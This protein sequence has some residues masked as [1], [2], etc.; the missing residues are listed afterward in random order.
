MFAE[1]SKQVTNDDKFKAPFGNWAKSVQQ[2]LNYE[3]AASR[4]ILTHSSTIG[5]I[6]EEVIRDILSKFLPLSV[7]IGTGQLVDSVGNLSDQVDIVIAKNSTPVFRFGGGV[8]AFLYDTV[9]A[10]IE[11]KSMLYR[12]KLKEA[13]ENSFSVKNLIHVVDIRSKGPRLFNQAFD[14]VTNI[15]GL[16]E[17]EQRLLH[18]SLTNTLDLPDDIAYVLAYVRYWLHWTEGDYQNP[19]IFQKFPDIFNE[20]EFDFFT[21]LLCYT[22]NENN[23]FAVLTSFQSR[24]DEIRIRFFEKLYE[25]LLYEEMPPATFVLAYGGYQ[26]IKSM[27]DEVRSWYLKNKAKVGWFEMPKVI[28]NHKMVMYR[29]FNEYHC[30]EF[31]Y[32]V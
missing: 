11:V 16:N 1:R 24:S 30:H 20:P 8:S 23:S 4:S 5:A 10:T 28:M 12:D 25:Y 31:E 6:R 17:L 21:N 18:P 3:Y 19:E 29:R 32:P 27:V 26:N 7:E 13:L 2:R 22:F 14:W 15:G 9:L